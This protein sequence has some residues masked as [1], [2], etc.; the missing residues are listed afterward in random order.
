MSKHREEHFPSLMLYSDYDR[1]AVKNIFD[2]EAP[3]TPGA[4]KWGLQGVAELPDEPGSFV[5]FVSYGRSQGEHEFD[6]GINQD[7]LLRWQSQPKQDLME[8]RIQ[9][10]IAHNP[11]INSIHLFLRTA[12]RRDGVPAPFTYLGE[13][14]YAGHDPERE[15]PVHFSWRLKCWPMPDDVLER[16]DLKIEG[17]ETLKWETPKASDA[18]VTKPEGL[19]QSKAPIRKSEQG[20]SAPKKRSFKPRLDINFAGKSARARKIGLLGEV[21]V[22]E[23]ER[24]R[25]TDC[26]RKDLAKKV[27]HVAKEKGD[28]AGYD[29]LSYFEDGREMFI[30]VKATTLGARTDFLISANEI[31]FSSEFADQYR[32]YRLYH[33]DEKAKA[34]DF[35][36]LKGDIQEQF[37]AVPT[38]FR[39]T[40]F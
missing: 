24:Q 35:F 39:V 3:F 40:G 2:P 30:E 7:G 9:S 31:A 25:L 21:L 5:F 36:V 37:E 11:D 20:P 27:I 8:R 33:L 29:V 16:I 1:E 34:A 13:L 19:V 23:F 4:G 12:L 28:G 15:Q 32:L 17:G 14:E 18:G 38:E 10:W 26:G 6:E 22:V